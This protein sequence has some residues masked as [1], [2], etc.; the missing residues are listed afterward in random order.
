[1]CTHNTN[2]LKHI[3]ANTNTHTQN[4]GHQLLRPLPLSLCVSMVTWNQQDRS[5]PCSSR[6]MRKKVQDVCLI[7]RFQFYFFGVVCLILTHLHALARTESRHTQTQTHTHAQEHTRA[8]KQTPIF[9]LSPTHTRTCANSHVLRCKRVHRAIM[10][11]THTHIHTHTNM[12]QLWPTPTLTTLSHAH[13]Q[14]YKGCIAPFY[15]GSPRICLLQ[16]KE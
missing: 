1:V 7:A 5:F 13:T 6:V 3:Y 10:Q 11:H 2:L 14:H 9:A 12:H 16:A 4:R 8:R 15:R